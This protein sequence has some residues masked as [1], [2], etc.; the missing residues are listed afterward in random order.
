MIHLSDLAMRELQTERLALWYSEQLCRCMLFP[1]VDVLAKEALLHEKNETSA[2]FSTAGAA[3]A[4]SAALPASV[5]RARQRICSCPLLPICAWGNLICG[6][7]CWITEETIS[8]QPKD[9][10]YEFTERFAG[11][12]TKIHGAGAGCHRQ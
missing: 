3:F 8:K 4:A 2:N 11:Q 12:F 6:F 1:S 7:F 10:F 5:P 9:Y